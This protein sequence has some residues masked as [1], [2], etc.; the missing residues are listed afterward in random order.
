[1]TKLTQRY[2]DSSEIHVGDRVH[3]NAQAGTVVFVIDHD[4]YSPKF[5]AEVVVPHS[6]PQ[7]RS[8]GGLAVLGH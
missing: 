1:M 6:L 3:Y 7:V 8:E 5:P 4:E 2:A